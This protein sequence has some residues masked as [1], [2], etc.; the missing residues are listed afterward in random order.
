MSPFSIHPK[1]S[2]FVQG[3]ALGSCVTVILVWI[4]GMHGIVVPNE[5]AQAF[6]G[7]FG[8]IIGFFF[9]YFATDKNS[10]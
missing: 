1:V 2:A 4:L 3:G 5:V 8:G 9:A 7:L 6:T 10:A